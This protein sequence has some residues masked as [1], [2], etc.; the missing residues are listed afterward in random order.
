MVQV[1]VTGTIG[2][3]G[4]LFTT[5]EYSVISGTVAYTPRVRTKE[6]QWEDGETV[7]LDFT[8]WGAEAEN[9][10]RCSPAKGL[11]VMM[12]GTMQAKMQKEFTTKDG[13]TTPA[14]VKNTLNV[15]HVAIRPTKNLMLSWE[16]KAGG[17]D[18]PAKKVAPAK[19]PAKKTEAPTK[20]APVDTDDFDDGLE[21]LDVDTDDS[22]FDDD[23]FGG[24]DDDP[25]AEFDD[26]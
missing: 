1:T 23:V 10:A 15:K 8:I 22:P 2:R 6:G 12:T 14:H 26:I 19:A 20:K 9:F 16:K 7:W 24:G 3:I 18:E 4:E 17:G 11:Q 21:D 5:S 25:F 13:N